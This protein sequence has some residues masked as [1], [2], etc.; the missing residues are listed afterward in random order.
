M[1]KRNLLL[2]SN[3]TLHPTGYLEYAQDIICDFLK[4]GSV[5]EVLFVPYALR[6]QDSYAGTVRSTF[7]KWGFQVNSV[8]EAEDPKLAVTKAQAIFIGGG[9]TFQLL[10]GLYDNNLIE[11]I[12]RRVL[13]EG[14]LYMGSSAGTNVSTVSINTTNDMPIV[15]PPSFA[16]LGLVPFNINPHYIDTDPNSTHKGETREER[17]MQYQEIPGTPPVLALR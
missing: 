17:I 1:S 3:S 15:F 4:S 2:L 7:A 8:H 6:D 13:N 14:V 5:S 12:K 11:L 10:K 16:A 9:N